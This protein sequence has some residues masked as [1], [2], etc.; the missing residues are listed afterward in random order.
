[1]KVFLI[2]GVIFCLMGM[3]ANTQN[4]IP[5]DT[6]KNQIIQSD[7]DSA[8]VLL[9][10]QLAYHYTRTD[11]D[12][13][14]L[15]LNEAATLARKID[16]PHGLSRSYIHL[17][18]LYRMKEDYS[19]SLQYA[20]SALQ[21]NTDTS[22]F[23]LIS[24]VYNLKGLIFARFADYEQALEYYYL[25]LDALITNNAGSEAFRVYDNI[26]TAY[27]KLKNFEKGQEYYQ[28]TLQILLENEMF[29]L[30]P[31]SLINIGNAYGETQ[32]YKE[33][34]EAY[35]EA[36]QY[37]EKFNNISQV[38]YLNANLGH[39]ALKKERSEQALK[40]LQKAENL[41]TKSPDFALKIKVKANLAKTLAMQSK[42]EQSKVKAKEAWQ[43][44]K[45]S[46]SKDDKASVLRAYIVL[47]EQQGDFRK[48]N[49][50]YTQLYDLKDSIFTEEMNTKAAEMEVRFDVQKKEHQIDLLNKENQL[51]KAENENQ[52]QRMMFLFIILGALILIIALIVILFIRTKRKNKE[53]TRRNLELMK[54]EDENVRLSKEANKY[55]D[56]KKDEVLQGL[57]ELLK[58]KKVYRN[59]ST[60]ID[61]LSAK[62]NTN[63]TYLSQIIN[64]HFDCNFK[65]FINRFRVSE[66][67]HLLIQPDHLNITI[68]AIAA[69]VGFASK[70]SFN[71]VFKKET[72]LTP[73]VF[74]KNAL[75]RV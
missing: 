36:L 30:V 5:P 8:K 27:C 21:A 63:R 58:D 50:F 53:L 15:L 40:Y 39:L 38:A 6:L 4:R 43:M 37:A 59:P 68:E 51:Q 10:N 70:S 52:R 13:A 61:E 45:Q 64:S 72:G 49:D 62:L 14:V 22:N 31:I 67:R 69:E 20:D 35:L 41:L 28:K 46:K 34:E 55:V 2:L 65:T 1:M 16:F 48:A 74:Q 73:S 75:K 47:N 7:S 71:M 9:K 3:K 12:S 19:M 54:V 24:N 17:G 29:P 23:S 25:A 26:G 60:S 32:E 66:A 44:A 57:E 33:A 56:A 18:E 11:F 42:F